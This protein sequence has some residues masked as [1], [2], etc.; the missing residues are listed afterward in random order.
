MGNGGRVT[1][2]SATTV[3]GSFTAAAP[4]AATALPTQAKR[5][6]IHGRE[7]ATKAAT[8]TTIKPAAHSATLMAIPVTTIANPTANA[9]VVHARRVLAGPLIGRAG[10]RPTPGH[11]AAGLGFMEGAMLGGLPQTKYS[12]A[13]C[14]AL[15]VAAPIFG[16]VV[17]V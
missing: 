2:G 13:C 14:C 16:M 6:A 5:S 7:V 9:T 15:S 3:P 12:C 17:N 4:Q 11:G 10:S 8:V 1:T